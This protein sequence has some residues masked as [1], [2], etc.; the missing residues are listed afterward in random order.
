MGLCLEQRSDP[1]TFRKVDLNYSRERGNARNSGGQVSRREIAADTQNSQFCL[2]SFESCSRNCS[3]QRQL[4]KPHRKECL[5]YCLPDQL[6]RE[7]DLARSGLRGRQQACSLRLQHA[8]LVK[9]GEVVRRRT[10]IR[11]VEYVE[12]LGAELRVKAFRNAP[13]VVVLKHG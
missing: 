7:L 2:C 4:R 3:P 10:K 6:Q 1:P 9:D 12:N 5:C 8:I 11:A 13:D